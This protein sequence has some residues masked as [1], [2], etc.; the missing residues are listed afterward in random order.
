MGAITSA[1]GLVAT[2]PSRKERLLAVAGG[3]VGALVVWA[4][5]E[6]VVGLDLR[7][8]AFSSDQ[9]PQELNAALVAVSSLVGGLAAW[10]VLA[11]LERFRAHAHRAW[12]VVAPIALLVSLSAPL[13]GTGISGSER[14]ALVAMHLAVA[15]VVIPALYRSSASRQD[16]IRV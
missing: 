16:W 5:A 14:I 6:F 8:P 4:V 10:G 3:V 13:S 11:L 15:A 12:L 1:S 2:R 7:T 9:Q